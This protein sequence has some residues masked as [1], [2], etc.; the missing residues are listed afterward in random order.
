M[1]FQSFNNFFE[2]YPSGHYSSESIAVHLAPWI[3]PY[4]CLGSLVANLSKGGTQKLNSGAGVL[5]GGEGE[6][7]KHGRLT[8][9]WFQARAGTGDGRKGAGGVA[10]ARTAV[11]RSFWQEG[12]RW[13]PRKRPGRMRATPRSSQRA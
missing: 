10:A 8:C 2:K 7:G 1:K 11:A 13:R 12:G 3:C 6:V 5:A 9:N 4:C